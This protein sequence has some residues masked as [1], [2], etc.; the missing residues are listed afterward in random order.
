[1]LRTNTKE[2]LSKGDWQKLTNIND[3]NQEILQLEKQK[4]NVRISFL[5]SSRMIF[6]R[7]F[8]GL[9]D[10]LSLHWDSA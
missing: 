4:K 2:Q 9:S 6:L 3:F 8:Q 7:N 5:N 10:L 1:M